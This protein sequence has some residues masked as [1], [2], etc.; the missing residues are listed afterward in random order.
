[1]AEARKVSEYKPVADLRLDPLNFRLPEDVPPQDQPGLCAFIEARYDLEELGLS[2]VR[3][4]FRPEEPLI[5]VQEDGALVVVEGNRRLSTLKL[6]TLAEFR[7]ALPRNRQELWNRLAEAAAQSGRD[8]AEAP[9]VVY[10]N[11]SQIEGSL[12]FRHVSGIAPWSA[13]SKA[14]YISHLVNQGHSYAQV[15]EMI[16][17]RADYVR[18]QYMAHAAL[19]EAADA[20]VDTSRAQRYFGVYY[21]A[22]SN[23]NTR[24]FVGL[25]W[26][27]DSTGTVLSGGSD[28]MGEFLDL[29]FGIEQRPPVVTDSRRVDEL[30]R[31][32]GNETALGVLRVERDLDAALA[33]LGGDKSVINAQLRGALTRLRQ[34]FGAVFDVEADDELIDLAEKCRVASE[35]VLDQL[36]YQR[37][38]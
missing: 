26:N 27:T 33:V 12:G 24:H 28:K 2:I 9:V 8:L 30:G 19:G 20:G 7:L 10:D 18:R 35:R 3:D 4:G 6:L 37:Q 14:R 32:L 38:P 15:A 11:R 13:E 31:V 1:M 36:R 16:G 5:A 29:L 25:D 22:L 17:S 34:A 21:R 23:V